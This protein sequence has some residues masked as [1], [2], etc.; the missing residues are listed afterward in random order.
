MLKADLHLHAGEDKEDKLRYSSKDLIKLA[1]KYKFNVLSLTFHN[2]FYYPKSIISYAKKHSI[3]LIPGTELTIQDK[4]ILIH[5]IKELPKIKSIESLEKIKDSVV[6]T[7]PHPFFPTSS[8]LGNLLKENIN[9]FDNIEYT[10]RYNS[11]LNFNKKAEEASLKYKKPLM[12]NSDCH[13]FTYFGKTF[14]NIDSHDNVESIL[15][16]LKKGRFK[17]ETKPLSSAWLIK[18]GAES[19]FEEYFLDKI[20]PKK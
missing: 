2:Q 17:M 12:G 20:F 19:V 18:S 11:L 14:T 9:L 16:S 15:D 3:I 8:A 4:H 6:I 13:H 7:A 10:A 1:E 5:G